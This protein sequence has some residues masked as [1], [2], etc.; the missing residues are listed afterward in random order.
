MR[1]TDTHEFPINRVYPCAGPAGIRV[2]PS[3]LFS[4]RAQAMPAPKGDR[5]APGPP[6][7]DNFPIFPHDA[8]D[9]WDG[10]RRRMERMQQCNA[11]ENCCIRLHW[12]AFPTPGR[13]PSPDRLGQ[14]GDAPRHLSGIVAVRKVLSSAI[15]QEHALERTNRREG[16][17]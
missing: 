14:I 9:G 7:I 13:P 10:E 15:H 4:L 3:P 6:E 17:G 8:G 1:N 11:L 12:V 5:H 16:E 2:H